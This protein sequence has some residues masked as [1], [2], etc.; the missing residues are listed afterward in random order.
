MKPW[1]QV[2]QGQISTGVWSSVD[3]KLCVIS[4]QMDFHISE[5]SRNGTP[6]DNQGPPVFTSGPAVFTILT[7][8]YWL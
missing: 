2:Q 5:D 3:P 8:A 7:V 1:L 6:A 4:F